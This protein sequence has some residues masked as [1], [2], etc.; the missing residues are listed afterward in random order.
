MVVRILLYVSG[1]GVDVAALRGPISILKS[2]NPGLLIDVMCPRTHQGELAGHPDVRSFLHNSDFNLADNYQVR[3]M[4]RRVLDGLSRSYHNVIDCSLQVAFPSVPA[5]VSVAAKE[6]LYCK[7]FTKHG[8]SVVP[9]KKPEVVIMDNNKPVAELADNPAERVVEVPAPTGNK[10]RGV[11]LCGVGNVL[12]Q[13]ANMLHAARRLGSQ[14]E[15][16]YV[17][18]N[19]PARKLPH[20]HG[21]LFQKIFSPWGG[22]LPSKWELSDFFHKLNFSKEKYKIDSSGKYIANCAEAATADCFCVV[23]KWTYSFLQD[24]EWREA[25]SIN[26]AIDDLL[27]KKW[28]HIDPSRPVVHIRAGA[29]GDNYGPNRAFDKKA[30]KWAFDNGKPYVITDNPSAINKIIADSCGSMKEYDILDSGDPLEDMWLLMQAQTLVLSR[31]TLS[32]WAAYLGRA[33][34][35]VIGPDFADEWHQPD[36]SWI[37]AGAQPAI[38]RPIECDA[39]LLSILVPTTPDRANYLAKLISIFEKQKNNKFE[40]VVYEDHKEKTTGEKRNR[41]LQEARG[42]WICFVD[43]DDEVVDDYIESIWPGLSNEY[44][45]VAMHIL[46]YENGVFKGNSFHSLKYD[47]WFEDRA[48]REYYRCPNHLNPVK[49]DLAITAGFPNKNH[50]EDSAYSLSLYPLLNKEYNA[51]KPLY[52]YFFRSRK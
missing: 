20:R 38:R 52:K 11:L 18:M 47:K 8:L 5:G 37:V 22:H 49:K 19:H 13:A 39:P 33:S 24:P 17:D 51:N 16:G 1:S 36:P 50:G 48:K 23:N 7:I 14:V 46:Y 25:F 26:P 9:V 15:L 42:E 45:V 4:P 21:G 43:D 40:L 27:K 10:I 31:S 6:E 32:M 44:D 35:V 34:Q 2:A 28:S 12:F 3:K 41:L 30:V 29:Q